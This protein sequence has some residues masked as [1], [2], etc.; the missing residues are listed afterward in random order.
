MGW[1]EYGRGRVGEAEW[2]MRVCVAHCISEAGTLA[3][4]K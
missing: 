2:L 4:E 1:K 3:F